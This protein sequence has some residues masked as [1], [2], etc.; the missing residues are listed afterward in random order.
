VGM[1]ADLDRLRT[2]QDLWR[3]EQPNQHDPRSRRL[4][5]RRPPDSSSC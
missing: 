3:I 4:A 5:P 2:S 1:M